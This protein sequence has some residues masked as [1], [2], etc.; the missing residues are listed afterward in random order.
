[1]SGNMVRIAEL[2]IDPAQIDTYRALLAEEIEASVDN[3]PGV[4]MLHAVSEKER[5][6]QVRILEVYANREA[7]E[8]HLQTPHFLKYKKCTADMVKSLRLI[9]ADPVM[10]RAK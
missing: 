8:A 1:M 7:Y 4:L 9:D 2:E 6:E 3:E 10:M 5:P